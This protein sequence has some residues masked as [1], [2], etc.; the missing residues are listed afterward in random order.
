MKPPMTFVSPTGFEPATFGTG[1]QCSH[2]LS[3]GDSLHRDV[4][5]ATLDT[6]APGVGWPVITHLDAVAGVVMSHAYV[7]VRGWYAEWVGERRRAA[8][9]RRAYLLLCNTPYVFS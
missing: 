8:G 1:N 6:V 9:A 2:P 3:Y 7:G 5:A 4:Y